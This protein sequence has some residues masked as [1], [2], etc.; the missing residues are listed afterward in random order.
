VS[1][2]LNLPDLAAPGILLLSKITQFCQETLNPVYSH[3]TR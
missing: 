2:L 1:E 3:M